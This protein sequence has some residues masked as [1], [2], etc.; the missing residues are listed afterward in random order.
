[1]YSTNRSY[2]GEELYEGVI[3]GQQVNNGSHIIF[4][5]VR[6]RIYKKQKNLKSLSQYDI[7]RLI[8]DNALYTSTQSGIDDVTAKATSIL[9]QEFVGNIAVV[10]IKPMKRDGVLRTIFNNRTKA[11]G[12]KCHY[13]T[14]LDCALRL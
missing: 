5:K 11:L 4:H 7:A 8:G 12:T 3:P 6:N 9:Q 1:M 13:F 10:L 14:P 2:H